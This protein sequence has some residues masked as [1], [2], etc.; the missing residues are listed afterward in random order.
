MKINK[1]KIKGLESTS[2]KKFFNVGRGIPAA[3]T[4]GKASKGERKRGKIIK[5]KE[6]KRKNEVTK[7]KLT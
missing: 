5:R 4:W 2:C 1:L 6:E 7:V 3:L